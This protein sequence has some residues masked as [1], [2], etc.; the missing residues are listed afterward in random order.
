MDPFAALGLPRRYDI[1]TDELEGRYRQLQRA[2]H[3]D[4]HVRASP[5]ERRLRLAKAMEVNEAFRTLRDE[6]QRANVLLELWGTRGETKPP[7]DP[8]FLMRIMQLREALSEAKTTHEASRVRSLA[9]RV[10]AMR[11]EEIQ[12]LRDGF[13]KLEGARANGDRSHDIERLEQALGRLRFYQRFLDETALAEETLAA[14]AIP[15][16]SGSS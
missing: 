7:P 6:L 3:P 15:A 10:G 4:R 13:R 12:V 5:G 11:E 1:A 9:D 2:L 16:V 8:E 14:S